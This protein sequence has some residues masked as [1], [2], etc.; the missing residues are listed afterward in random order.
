MLKKNESNPTN[1][2]CPAMKPVWLSSISD[3]DANLISWKQVVMDC[4]KNHLPG[5]LIEG[6]NVSLLPTYAYMTLVNPQCTWLGWS[7]RLPHISLLNRRVP[8]YCTPQIALW[9]CTCSKNTF[10]FH[11]MFLEITSCWDCTTTDKD[12][13]QFCSVFP[14][15]VQKSHLA[16]HK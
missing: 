5:E 4:Q 11:K 9:F 10:P 3:L 6:C 7:F 13:K 16:E 15:T 14:Q 2:W 8:K 1:V 12:S